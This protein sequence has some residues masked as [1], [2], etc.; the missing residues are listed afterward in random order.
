[1]IAWVYQLELVMLVFSSLVFLFP[2]PPFQ[3]SSLR[4]PAAFIYRSVALVLVFGNCVFIASGIAM[5]TMH[6]ANKDTKENEADLYQW[7][8]YVGLTAATIY[9][10]MLF[11]S[12]ACKACGA[13]IC[14][15]CTRRGATFGATCRKLVGNPHSNASNIEEKLFAPLLSFLLTAIVTAILPLMSI[16]VSIV[17]F[18]IIFLVGYIV[19]SWIS[20]GLAAFFVTIQ[21]SV[22]ICTSILFSAACLYESDDLFAMQPQSF[23]GVALAIVGTTTVLHLMYN[24]GIRK[25]TDTF[26]YDDDDLEPIY[27]SPQDVTPGDTMVI[28]TSTRKTKRLDDRPPPTKTRRDDRIES[29]ESRR[30][31]GPAPPPLPPPQ[32]GD[33]DTDDETET[34]V[35]AEVV[36]E[37]AARSAPHA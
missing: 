30:A 7:A 20:D 22:F 25:L 28:Q 5:V 17:T 6:V 32:P 13:A 33:S 8:A 23:Y 18:A 14:Y 11:V 19:L 2:L 1:M 15:T 24:Y 27:L 10:T 12:H 3:T 37:A 4:H 29:E 21:A 26:N 36:A 34:L 31:R 35:P 9:A 16:S